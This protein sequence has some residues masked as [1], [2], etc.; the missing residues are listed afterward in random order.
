MDCVHSFW[1]CTLIDQTESVL[2]R[3]ATK[4]FFLSILV[5][6]Q[7]LCSRINSYCSGLTDGI[8]EKK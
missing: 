3:E 7:I 4:F 1:T 8:Q 5:Y 2:D 6:L